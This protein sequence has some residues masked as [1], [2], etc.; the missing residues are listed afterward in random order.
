MHQIINKSLYILSI[1]SSFACGHGF[2]SNTLI[3]LVNGSQQTIHNVC[4]HALHN[5]ISVI[6]Y[7][8]S[9]ECI[10]RPIVIGKRSKANC[11]IQLSF[12]KQPDT[13]ND[14]ICT[15]TQE[16][17]IPATN[18]WVPAYLLK[19]GDALLTKNPSTKRITHKSFTPKDLKI[20]ML[21]IEQSHTFFVGKHAIL[22]HNILLPMAI[23]LGFVVPFGSVATSAV[24]SFFGPIGLIGGA[25]FGGVVG[26]AIK[27]FC[28]NRI[29]RYDAP[30][31]NI[32][33][34]QNSCH[35][36]ALNTDDRKTS[37]GCFTVQNS[38]YTSCIYPIENPLPTTS[39]GCIE[40]EVSI[41]N[42]Y[43]ANIFSKTHDQENISNDGCFQPV[44]PNEQLLCDSQEKIPESGESKNRYNGPKARNWKE[45]E[46]NCPIGQ[47]YGKKFIHTGRQ[48]PKDGSPIRELSEDIPNT[49]M[50][51]KGRLFAP[52]R[53]HEGD[54][55][56]VWD[57]KDRWIGVANLDGSKNHKKTNAETDKKK[58]KLHN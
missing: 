6:S 44:E 56:E 31:F 22:T 1:A 16:F 29:S 45:F 12:D 49:E 46:Q 23:N 8:M 27:A 57:K 55:F 40:I 43:I 13:A 48:N 37:S 38:L 10:N 58:R 17:Y 53:L 7:D 9:K 2:G 39:A 3:H 36:A 50:F 52:D 35:N 24:G 33:Y 30:V 20:Y 14:V 41:P 5:P 54:H 4:L 42:S 19:P 11:Y 25:I 32:E 21:E 47:K 34:I 28:K 18:Q 15:P 26:V 51:K